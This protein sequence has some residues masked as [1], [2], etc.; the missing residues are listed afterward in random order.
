MGEGVEPGGSEDAAAVGA[1]EGERG[2]VAP[3]LTW[4]FAAFHAALLVALVVA[5]LFA[6]GLAGNQ[7]NALDTSLG[8]VAYLYLWAVTWW[9]NRRVV[10]AVGW[11]LL[12]GSATRSDV[13][14]EALKWGGVAGLLVFLPAFAVVVV[15]VVAQGG[16]EAV[17][18]LLFAAVVGSVVAG[19]VGVLVGALSAL[20]DLLLVGI[21]RAWLP[22]DA[23]SASN[24]GEA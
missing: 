17:S 19:G 3:L 15:L 18:F 8:V 10:E 5:V 2:D 14:V 22:R 12:T 21:A 1:V 13:L 11:G 20:L 9:T 16:L 23:G 7:L 6:L 24:P 4:T